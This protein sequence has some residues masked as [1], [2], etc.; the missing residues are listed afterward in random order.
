M[1]HHS[2]HRSASVGTEHGG[3]ARLWW[4]MCVINDILRVIF[5]VVLH[6]SLNNLCKRIFHKM[7]TLLHSCNNKIHQYMI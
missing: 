7:L 1:S 4:K 5:F 2:F 3:V 6:L